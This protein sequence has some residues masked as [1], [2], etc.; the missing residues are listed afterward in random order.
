MHALSLPDSFY[1]TDIILETH[2]AYLHGLIKLVS[3]SR[4]ISS[5]IHGSKSRRNVMGFC[6]KGLKLDL[7]GSRCSTI[8]QLNPDI[9]V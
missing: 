7:I 3:N 5:F 1:S 2:T 4:W 9:S 8:S 6:L